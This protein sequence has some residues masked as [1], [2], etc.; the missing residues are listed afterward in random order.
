MSGRR[1]IVDG[2]VF[3]TLCFMSST[4]H[5]SPFSAA[6]REI[7]KLMSRWIAG[8]LQRERAEGHMRKLSSAVEQTAKFGDHHRLRGNC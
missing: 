6:E 4:P 7:L 1:I 3:G 2:A 5:R 8:E